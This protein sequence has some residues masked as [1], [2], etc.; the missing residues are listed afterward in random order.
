[1]EA[2]FDD[3]G[4]CDAVLLFKC[5]SVL[6][7]Q[8]RIS[9]TK[10]N[11][12]GEE[13]CKNSPDFICHMA[14]FDELIK[15]KN[16]AKKIFIFETKRL[17]GTCYTTS[18]QSLRDEPTLKVVGNNFDPKLKTMTA[19]PFCTMATMLKSM[20]S[21]K[22]I[23]HEGHAFIK[24]RQEAESRGLTCS[25]DAPPNPNFSINQDTMSIPVAKAECESIGFQKGSD[26]YPDCVLELV[27]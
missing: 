2:N 11:L 12:W 15:D 19:K 14:I 7:V 26:K 9:G 18:N 10:K 13:G 24:Y 21:D 4:R 23:W 5:T 6:Y 1:M 25:V 8:R 3:N 16:T 22:R 20:Y 17:P 27:K